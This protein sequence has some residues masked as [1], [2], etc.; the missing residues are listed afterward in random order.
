MNYQL[1]SLTY[2]TKVGMFSGFISNIN[3]QYKDIEPISGLQRQIQT[4]GFGGSYTVS[5]PSFTK[6]DRKDLSLTLNYQQSH[7]NSNVQTY[8]TQSRQ[9][10]AILSKG[11]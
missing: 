9:Y 11:F 6:P 3:N 5:L 2:L 8:N 1:A 7:G 4:A 10:M